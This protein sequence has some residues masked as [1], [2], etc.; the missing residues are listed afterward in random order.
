MRQ[1]RLWGSGQ[2]TLSFRSGVTDQRQ[3]G[4]A[5]GWGGQNAFRQRR[6]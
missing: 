5:G 3:G 4:Q 2:S 6:A 1:T